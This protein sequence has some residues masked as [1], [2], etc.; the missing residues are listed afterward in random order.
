MVKEIRELG[1][2]TS[3][4]GTEGSGNGGDTDVHNIDAEYGRA[5]YY[6]ASDFGTMQAGHS[7][8]RSAGVSAVVGAGRNR[9][10]GGEK[11]GGGI[12]DKIRDRVG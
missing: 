9:P 7:A 1:L 10:G 11:T 6:N 12:N 5:I 8:A 2:P 3:G 4:G